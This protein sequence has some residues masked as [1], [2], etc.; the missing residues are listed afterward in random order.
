VITKRTQVSSVIGALRKHPILSLKL[1][2]DKGLQD[3]LAQLR[4]LKTLRRFALS[5]VQ[6]ARD[7]RP[8]EI[9][10]STN[11][12]RAICELPPSVEH[13]ELRLDGYI[14]EP[15]ALAPLFRRGDLK[16]RTLALRAPTILAAMLDQLLSAAWA[17][18]LET[19]DAALIG[20][21][22]LCELLLA[23]RE[24]FPALTELRLTTN[25]LP[26]RLLEQLDEHY[27]VVHRGDR[28]AK[29][30]EDSVGAEYFFRP[31]SE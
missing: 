13:I 27:D 6:C 10:T 5:V 23:N 2:T 7:E 20:A 17:P 24:R 30:F 8:H 19:L 18:T 4:S 25:V 3:E 11:V 16:L 28:D 21:D 22:R 31:I 9:E 1:V 12:L 29:F 26:E 14:D 15:D